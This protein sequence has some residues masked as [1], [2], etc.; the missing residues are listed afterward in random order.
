MGEGARIEGV[1]L[2]AGIGAGYTLRPGLSGEENRLSLDGAVVANFDTYVSD[3]RSFRWIAGVTGGYEYQPQ[4]GPG[5]DEGSGDAFHIGGMLGTYFGAYGPVFYLGGDINPR[6]TWFTGND[7]PQ[8]ELGL[9]LRAIATLGNFNASL[10]VGAI[11][12]TAD[13]SRSGFQASL[14]ALLYL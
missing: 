8:F 4:S 2:N 10:S 5:F 14:A 6:A 11:L 13:A 9:N 1:H 7:S 3:W 12:N